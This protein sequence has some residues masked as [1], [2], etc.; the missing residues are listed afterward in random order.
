M[1]IASIYRYDTYP[2]ESAMRYEIR[3]DKELMYEIDSIFSKYLS[4]LDDTEYELMRP[5]DL[6]HIKDT[7]DTLMTIRNLLNGGEDNETDSL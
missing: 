6:A 3:C 1:K 4:S 2:E 7:I 5:K